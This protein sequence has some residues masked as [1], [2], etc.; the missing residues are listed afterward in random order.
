VNIREDGSVKI[1]DQIFVAGQLLGTLQG[2]RQSD[3][4]RKVLIRA[5]ERSRMKYFA[6]VA[7]QCREAGFNEA[8][9]VYVFDSQPQAP[10][11]P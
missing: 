1:G 7:R 11:T 5:D 4:G 10:A 2:A 8:K 6:D 9:I 3:P